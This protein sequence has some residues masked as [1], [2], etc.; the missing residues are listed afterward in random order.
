MQDDIEAHVDVSAAIKTVVSLAKRA[1]PG[2]DEVRVLPG[3]QADAAGLAA[4]IDAVT[5]WAEESAE[6][7]AGISITTTDD[8]RD[9]D[10]IWTATLPVDGN[11]IRG[12]LRAIILW[13]DQASINPEDCGRDV[14]LADECDRQR[15]ALDAVSVLLVRHGYVLSA[16]PGSARPR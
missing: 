15:N 6:V 5:R 7:L 4:S 16:G 12:D 8:V 2:D 13:A 3:L 9:D 11:D 10:P 14:E 1:A